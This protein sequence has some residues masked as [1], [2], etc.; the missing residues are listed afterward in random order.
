MLVAARGLSPK[1]LVGVEVNGAHLSVAAERLPRARLLHED[2][3][4]TDW[5]RLVEGP[6]LL[7]GNPPWVTSAALGALDSDLRPHGA[8]DLKGLDALTGKSNFDVSQWLGERWLQAYAHRKG[9]L[10][11]V[12]KA[13]VARK[14]LAF[15][16]REGLPIADAS[17]HVIDARR[18][19]EASVGACVL[20]CRLG[21]RGEPRCPVYPDLDARAP[22]RTLGW[23]SDCG[24]IADLDAFAEAAPLI[25]EG[26]QWRS[27]VKHDCARVLVL[28]RGPDG[29]LVNG[30]GEPVHVEPEVLYPLMRG[31]DVARGYGCRR[32]LLLPQREVGAS[33]EGLALSAPKAWAYLEAHRAVFEARRSRIYQGKPPYSIFGVGPYSFTDWKIAVSGLHREIVFQCVGPEKGRPVLFDDTVY[34]LP[35]ADE[36]SARARHA[37]LSS[38]RIRR[39]FDALVFEDAKRPVTARLLRRLVV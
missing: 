11:L 31:T 29:V 14:L 22:S 20:I 28:E 16:W 32:W 21:V 10:A 34:V 18:W 27:G 25:G 13:S 5:Q 39:F 6:V 9:A 19:F 8:H 4:T 30:L 15:A 24:L 7:V 3:F 38:M 37:A 35:C 23:S 2:A 36:A 1:A 12:L 33:T 26:P 17:M